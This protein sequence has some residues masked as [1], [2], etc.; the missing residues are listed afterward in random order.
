[1]L[2]AL[3]LIYIAGFVVASLLLCEPEDDVLAAIVSFGMALIWPYYAVAFLIHK[4]R[5]AR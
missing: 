1:M 2:T 5:T 3:T 4:T